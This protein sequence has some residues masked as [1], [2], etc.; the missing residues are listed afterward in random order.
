MGTLIC[1][2]CGKELMPLPDVRISALE[3]QLAA[4]REHAEGAVRET[5]RLRDAIVEVC[6]IKVNVVVPDDVIL[7]AALRARDAG[8]VDWPDG[9]VLRHEDGCGNL[10]ITAAAADGEGSEGG[11]R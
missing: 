9:H 8:R 5:G 7:I 2:H 3:S 6:G 11:G 1:S 4:E 10:S